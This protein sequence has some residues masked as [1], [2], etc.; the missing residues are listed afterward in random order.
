MALDPK[1]V[2]EYAKRVQEAEAATKNAA[3][4]TS[5]LKEQLRDVLFFTRD[6]A[7]E[8]RKASKEVNGSTIAASETAK[9]FKDVASAAKKISDNYAEVLTGEKKYKDLLKERE[10]LN[11]A[12]RSFNT[13]HEQFL[14]TLQMSQEDINGILDGSIDTYEAIDRAGISMSD[15]QLNLL[16]L[17]KLQNEQLEDEAD[18]IDEVAKRASTIEDA[19]GG[20]AVG[21]GDLAS[22]LDGAMK[23]SG[24]GDIADKMD[25]QGAIGEAQEFAGSLTEGGTK[26]AGM[27]GKMKVAGKMASSIGKNLMKS[28]GPAALLAFAIE[29]LVNAFK[30]ID[31]K[32][33]ELAKEFGVSAKEGQKLVKSA[34]KAAGASG[35]LLTSTTDLIVAQQTLNNLYGTAVEFPA[36]MATEFAMISERTGLSAD[37]MKTFSSLALTTGSTIKDQLKDITLTTLEMNSQSGISLNMK[38]VQEGISKA[39]SS[40]LLMAGRSTKELTRQVFAAKALGVEQSKVEAIGDSLLDFESSISKELEAELLLGRD[41]N[42]EKARAAALDGDRATVAE[43]IKK[44]VGSTADFMELNTIEAEALAAAVGMTREELSASMIEADNLAALQKNGFDSISDAQNQYNALRAEGYSEEEAALAIGDKALANQ[45]ESATMADK[46]AAAQEKIQDLFVAIMGAL[47]PVF[48]ILVDILEDVLNPIMEALNPILAL[49]GELLGAILIP[50]S[51]ILQAAI[52]PIIETMVPIVDELVAAFAEVGESLSGIFGEAEE[53][54]GILETIGDIIGTIILV[55]MR[56]TMYT[57]SLITSALSG[58]ADM[59]SGIGMMIE[60]DFLGGFKKIGLGLMRILTA[61]FQAM[62]DVAIGTINALIRLGNKIPG[63]NMSEFG[64]VDIMESMGMGGEVD[65][66]KEELGG[67]EEEEEGEIGLA[68]GGIVT[69]PTRAL[70]GEGGEPEAVIPLSK[71]KSMGFGGNEKVIQLLE[72]LISVV[73]KG[74]VVELDGNKVGTALGMVSYKTQ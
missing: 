71:A 8:A 26:A 67:G 9:A 47:M 60:G 15:S 4:S 38:Q 74:G 14:N 55:P 45:F 25:I 50:I 7:D 51:K 22:G 72:R 6:Y 54:S 69:S 73:E 68:R 40:A 53:G 23:K 35:D 18:N 65:S 3:A 46:M 57:I 59:F 66:V 49:F 58:L 19:M 5:D 20:S 33:G 21:L 29:G 63:V 48:N 61:P 43:E 13:E 70:I 12:Q 56:A 52:K 44:Q 37:A 41:L 31:G 10:A 32:S 64:D 39:S 24:L 30:M 11:S 1:L 34:N 16:E 62:I 42:L 2:E 36:E 17:Y 27:G 28:L